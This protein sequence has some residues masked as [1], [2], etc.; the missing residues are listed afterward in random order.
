LTASRIDLNGAMRTGTGASEGRRPRQ[1]RRALVAFDVALA[2]VLLAGASLL[3]RSFAKVLA[4]DPGFR[5]EGALTMRIALPTPAMQD[6]GDEQR[7]RAFYGRVLRD[8]RS[9]PGVDAAGAISFLPMSGVESDRLFE[10]EGRPTPPGGERPDAQIRI[11]TPGYFD[12][13]G[14]PLL[15]GRTLSQLDGPGAP[16][17]VV[18]NQSFARHFFPDAEVLGHRIRLDGRWYAVAG[19][20]GDVREFGLDAPAPPIM[21][22]ALDQMPRGTMTVVLRSGR[23]LAEISRAASDAVGALDSQLPVY[24]VRPSSDLLA[25]SLAQRRFALAL[26]TSLAALALLLAALGLYG[27]LAYSV[28]QRTREIGVRMALGA[29][30]AGVLALVVRESAGVVIAGLA[31]GAVGAAISARFIG[32]LLYGVRPADPLAFLAAVLAL[33]AAAALAS[34]LPARRA[35]RVDPV[36]ALR[37]E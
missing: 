37:S 27:V 20:V 34:V 24:A 7:Q 16:G 15:L 18:V 31:V 30:P 12:A 14:M 28:A 19:V 13:A 6:G 26:L 36:I 1:L 8:L 9:I 11:A 10:I 4:V 22:F 33:A 29:D 32:S 23:S 3:L 5:T 35:T 2:L 21:Y 25:G 17:A